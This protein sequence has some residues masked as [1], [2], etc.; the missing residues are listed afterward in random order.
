MRG[1][2]MA[3]LAGSRVLVILAPYVGLIALLLGRRRIT[4]PGYIMTDGFVALAATEVEAI[5]VHVNIQISARVGQGAV[6]I[7]MLHGVP[8]AAVEVTGTAIFATALADALRD[9]PQIDR[10]YDPA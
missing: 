2:A 4:T 8:P 10:L 1:V 9:C 7:A 5:L 6:E 3:G